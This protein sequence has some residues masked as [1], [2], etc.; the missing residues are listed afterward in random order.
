M[1]KRNVTGMKP[2][3]EIYHN[4]TTAMTAS[5]DIFIDPFFKSFHFVSRLYLL[6]K[7]FN[8]FEL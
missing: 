3:E 2:Y 5:Y 7:K 6:Y 1:N 4:K 8:T